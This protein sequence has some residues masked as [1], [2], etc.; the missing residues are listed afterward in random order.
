MY[1]I[2]KVLA[3]DTLESIANKFNTDVNTLLKINSIDDNSF[4]PGNGIIVPKNNLYLKEYV[5]RE[6]DTI[7]SIA[8]KNNV[9]K[10]TLLGLNGLNEYDYIYPNQVILI[11]NENMGIYITK[12]SDTLNMVLNNL[13]LSADELISKN[14][15]IFLLPDQLIIYKKEKSF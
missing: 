9:S 1:T 14:E 10:D 12:N 3:G 6:G 2:Y 5:V 13:N 7:Y 15:K 8:R 4:L 11:P